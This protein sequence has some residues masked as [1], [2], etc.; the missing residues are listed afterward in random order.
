MEGQEYLNQISAKARPQQQRSRFGKL[1]S[2]KIFVVSM[3]GLILLIIIL[4]IGAI[5]GGSKT[6]EKELGYSLK[7]HVDNTA[8]V[9]TEYQSSVKSST[10]RSNSA[11]LLSILSHTSRELTNYLTNKYSYKSGEEGEKLVSEA[12][13]N[14]DGLR[15]VLFNAK[16]N[17]ILDRIYAH[18]VAYEISMILNEESKLYNK[19]SNDDLKNI[20]S[21][22]YSSLENLYS[23]FND[24]SEAK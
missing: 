8:S 18:Q 3:I 9:V 5:L 10:L 2:S 17:G 19:T 13:L 20:L 6:N 22:S 21:T 23:G 12:Q 16:I 1:M 7:L 11:S 14:M 4:I 24:F 15:A